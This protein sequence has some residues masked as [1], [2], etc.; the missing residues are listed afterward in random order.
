MASIFFS[1]M[2]YCRGGMTGRQ[3]ADQARIQRPNLK[4]LFTTG[5]TKNAIVHNGRLDDGVDLLSKPYTRDAFGKKDQ[6]RAFFQL[7]SLR[8]VVII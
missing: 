7:D 6:N 2:S 3:L 4:I 1:R 8:R 5:Y